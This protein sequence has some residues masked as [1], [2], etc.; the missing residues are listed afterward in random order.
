ME[1]DVRTSD[2]VGFKGE[3]AVRS[4]YKGNPSLPQASAPRLLS[5]QLIDCGI[6]IGAGDMRAD[7]VENGE[8]ALQHSDNGRHA[9]IARCSR[10]KVFH[11]LIPSKRKPFPAGPHVSSVAAE[12]G[13]ISR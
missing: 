13:V 4:F 9:G 8:F 2:L 10:C 3:Y 11:S 12:T 5:P 6:E 1:P 7:F